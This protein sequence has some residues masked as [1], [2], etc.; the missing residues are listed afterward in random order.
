MIIILSPSKTLDIA[1]IPLGIN[2]TRPEFMDE[3]SGLM[4]VM[5]SFNKNDLAHNMKLSQSL[6]LTVDAWHQGWTDAVNEAYP[7]AFAMKGEAFKALDMGSLSNDD[8]GYAQ[9][10][11]FILSGLYGALRPCDGIKPFRLEM[12]QKFKPEGESGTLNGFWA[13][14]LIKYFNEKLGRETTLVNLASDEY[15]KVLLKS[16][17]QARVIN[18]DF[19]VST[20]KGLK[21]ISVF[22]KQ[23]RGALARF[24]IRNRIEDIEKLKGFNYLD[25]KFNTELSGPEKL[26]FIKEI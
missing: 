21:S 18:F 17:L 12:G 16:T 7:A 3:A 2:T 23:A 15:S 9:E 13:E 6:S 4:K 22:S 20:D 19:K 26:T 5:K 8:V 10:R 24:I 11:L 1:S 14:R 25:Y